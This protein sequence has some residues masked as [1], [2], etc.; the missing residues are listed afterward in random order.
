MRR[1]RAIDGGPV[2]PLLKQEEL[3]SDPS[4]ALIQRIGL[5]VQRDAGADGYAA[6]REGDLLNIVVMKGEKRLRAELR[7]DAVRVM[8]RRELDMEATRIGLA[9]RTEF[10]TLATA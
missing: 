4:D 1:M 9:L 10:A 2:S 5:R 8:T 3:T 6:R 7:M